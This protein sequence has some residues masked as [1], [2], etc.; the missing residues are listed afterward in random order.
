MALNN[1]ADTEATAAAAVAA[2]SDRQRLGLFFSLL[3]SSQLSKQTTKWPLFAL[4]LSQSEKKKEEGEKT[5]DVGRWSDQ[6]CEMAAAVDKG[7]H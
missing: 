5:A 2:I 1:E 3:F 6:A 4:T 7:D